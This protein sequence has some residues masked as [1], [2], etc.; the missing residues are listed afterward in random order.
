MDDD[1]LL[2]RGRLGLVARTRP[3]RLVRGAPSRGPQPPHGSPLQPLHPCCS[4]CNPACAQAATLHLH[5][6]YYSTTY[7]SSMVHVSGARAADAADEARGGGARCQAVHGPHDAAAA[8]ACGGGGARPRGAADPSPRGAAPRAPRTQHSASSP[9]PPKPQEPTP[10]P[11]RRA[12]PHEARGRHAAR[13]AAH[14]PHRNRMCWRL[15]PRVQDAGCM[16]MCPLPSALCPGEHP[17][18]CECAI[19]CVAAHRGGHGQPP[20]PLSV[21]GLMLGHVPRRP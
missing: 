15:Q 13:Y 19:V 10:H 17:Q 1:A 9:R 7:L 18:L 11:S 21:L 4:R 8:S 3:R 20:L 16:C 12:E 6:Y 5:V 14:R 2:R